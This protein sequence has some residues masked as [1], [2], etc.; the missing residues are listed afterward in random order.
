MCMVFILQ[1]GNNEVGNNEKL[2]I[3][4]YEVDFYVFKLL[5]LVFL[6]KGHSIIIIVFVFQNDYD[7]F[8]N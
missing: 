6:W 7:K 1:H 2:K 5:Y 4:T 8:E 3:S